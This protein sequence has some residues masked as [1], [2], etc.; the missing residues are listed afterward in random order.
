MRPGRGCGCGVSWH[1]ALQCIFTR[2]SPENPDLPFCRS[3]SCAAPMLPRAVLPSSCARYASASRGAGC[4]VLVR[5]VHEAGADAPCV[6][7][8]IASTINPPSTL[9][10]CAHLILC[11]W[12]PPPSPPL[13][14][15]LLGFFT[16]PTW[17]LPVSAKVVKVTA[18]L[19]RSEAQRPTSRRWL[20]RRSS[21]TR[22]SRV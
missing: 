19:D 15:C 12:F 11:S 9:S 8:N 16:L 22:P 13:A 2:L 7:I 4:F 3:H 1:P 21:W 10:I 18:C 5:Q 14:C 20:P 6:C 17:N